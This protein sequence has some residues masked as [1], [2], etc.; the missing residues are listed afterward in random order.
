MASAKVPFVVYALG[1]TGSY[2]PVLP[3]AGRNAI[4]VAQS[5]GRSISEVPIAAPQTSVDIG[6]EDAAP[7]G[8]ASSGKEHD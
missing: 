2:A 5:L 6:S 1:N 3:I 7:T 8:V 4:P